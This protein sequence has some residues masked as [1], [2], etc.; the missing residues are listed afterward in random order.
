MRR[1]ADGIGAASGW[2]GP[3]AWLDELDHDDLS[4]P[5]CS[6]AEW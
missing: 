3:C 6:A 5:V 2:S 1:N 4:D